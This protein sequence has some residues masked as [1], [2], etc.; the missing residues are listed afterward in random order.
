MRA[1]ASARPD[2][3]PAV[4]TVGPCGRYHTPRDG[5]E[6]GHVVGVGGIAA[7]H[8]NERL[9]VAA[10]DELAD[11]RAELIVASRGDGPSETRRGVSG[12]VARDQPAGEPGGAPDDDVEGIPRGGIGREGRQG[13]GVGREGRA[14]REGFGS[15]GSARRRRGSVRAAGEHRARGNAT[16]AM[17]GKGETERNVSARRDTSARGAGRTVDDDM[18]RDTLRRRGRS[19][20]EGAEHGY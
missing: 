14:K 1:G 9:G 13:D 19:S 4:R 8:G 16:R 15:G 20:R 5:G 11:E 3:D 6:A 12:E 17:G 10:V 7:E 2:E 18:A